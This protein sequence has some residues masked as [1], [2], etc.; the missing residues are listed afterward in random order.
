L[1]LLDQIDPADL[2]GILDRLADRLATRLRADT[3]RLI[4]LRQLAARL[5]LSPRGVTGLIGR[6]EL[7]Q[8]ILLGGVRRWSWPKVEAFL[9]TREGHRP[10]KGRGIRRIVEAG[11]KSRDPLLTV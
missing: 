11:M 7:P 4:D 2:D 5:Q 1:N 9:A 6:N 3:D 8:G 10:R